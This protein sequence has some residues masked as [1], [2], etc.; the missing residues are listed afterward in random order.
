MRKGLI[1]IFILFLLLVG[2]SSTV[3]KPT[4]VDED[5][6]NNI[7]QYTI[8]LSDKVDSN[9]LLG[10]DLLYSISSFIK[11]TNSAYEDLLN[12]TEKDIFIAF[13]EY[14]IECLNT[15]MMIALGSDDY[16]SVDYEETYNKLV[17]IYGKE[18]LKVDN[19]DQEFLSNE[20]SKRQARLEKEIEEFMKRTKTR[21]YA[22]DVQYDMVWI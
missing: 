4:D 18:N 7:Q 9:E 19:L 15:F 14:Y 6:W 1:L 12:D 8:I 10:D 11:M 16:Y 5:F 17:E 22:K 20:L 21:L 3:A 2:C 13:K